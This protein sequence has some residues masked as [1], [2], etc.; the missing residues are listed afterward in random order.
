MAYESNSRKNGNSAAEGS[1]YE[2]SEECVAV[3]EVSQSEPRTREPVR[4]WAWA[5]SQDSYDWMDSH[6]PSEAATREWFH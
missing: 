1:T 5:H 3:A 6:S 4:N 2:T